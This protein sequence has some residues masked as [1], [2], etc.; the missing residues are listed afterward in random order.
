M[1]GWLG[2]RHVPRL[3]VAASGL[4]HC[5]H[6]EEDRSPHDD[7]VCGLQR[8]TARTALDS[9]RISATACVGSNG[10]ARWG[11][12][13]V[14]TRSSLIGAAA[15]RVADP[16]ERPGSVAGS[17]RRRARLSQARA[18]VIAG[19]KSSAFNQ[20]ALDA[21]AA[22]ADIAARPRQTSSSAS[23]AI[24]RIILQVGAATRHHGTA[25]SKRDA[26]EVGESARTAA[27][28]IRR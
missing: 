14:R 3:V 9:L 28:A 16:H 2:D 24:V 1:L 25:W 20:T 19:R 4:R 23:A 18:V 22:L 15:C 8:R 6:P 26:L 17:A 12:E 13:R 27:A 21:G 10:A 11:L 5:A 7:E